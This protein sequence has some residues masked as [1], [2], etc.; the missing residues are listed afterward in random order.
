MRIIRF[1]TVFAVI[2]LSAAAASAQISLGGSTIEPL[3]AETEIVDLSSPA[4]SGSLLVSVDV[5]YPDGSDSTFYYVTSS[6]EA[7]VD[8]AGV[9]MSEISNMMTIHNEEA[10]R[11]LMT[12]FRDR[13]SGIEVWF[14]VSAVKE[15]S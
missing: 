13:F 1:F 10:I 9:A 6:M 7:A 14:V 11:N 12:H 2:V 3:G 4:G 5:D 8:A 15:D